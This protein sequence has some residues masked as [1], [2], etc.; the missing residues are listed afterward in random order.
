MPL[1]LKFSTSTNSPVEDF[2]TGIAPWTEAYANAWQFSN[3]NTDYG[4]MVNGNTTYIQYGHNDPSIWASMRFWGETVDILEETTN[5]D[6]SITAKIRVKA[7]FWW[8]KR[9]SSKDG[10]RVDYDI[11]INNVS[12]WTFSGYTTDEVIKNDESSQEFTVTIP[13]GENSSASALNINVTY[14]NGEYSNNS[15][16]IGMFL[17]NTNETNGGGSSEEEEKN[18]KPWAIRKSGIFKTLNRPSGIFQQRKGSWNDISEQP[19]NAVGQAVST[20]HSVRK[21]GQWIGQG[22]I[23]LQ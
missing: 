16:Y 18:I 3:S 20:H 22:E 15:F 4:Y 6:K 7:L 14:P 11:R 19:A 17:Y 1:Q 12:V 8:S 23:G 5:A 10:Y 2:G 21:S 13:A 9:V